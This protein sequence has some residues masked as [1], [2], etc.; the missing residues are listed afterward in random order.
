VRPGFFDCHAHVT[1]HTTRGPFPDSPSEAEYMA[2]YTRWMNALEPEDEYASALL[3][4]LEILR[5]GVICFL[6]P[7][8]AFEPDA[9]VEAA[10]RTGIRGYVTDP[11]IWD[12]PRVRTHHPRANASTRRSQ[13]GAPATRPATAGDVKADDLFTVGMT[14][15]IG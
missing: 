12:L 9:A 11:Y 7:G 2:Y 1:L 15:G 10:K 13:A 14:C 8:M 5:N 6:E 4:Y 3:A